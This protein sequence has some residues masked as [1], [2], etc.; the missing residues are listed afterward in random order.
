VVA[1]LREDHLQRLPSPPVLENPPPYNPPCPNTPLIVPSKV[2]SVALLC[3]EWHFSSL[4]LPK[5]RVCVTSMAEDLSKMERVED[6]GNSQSLHF[7]LHQPIQYTPCG[8]N[9]THHPSIWPKTGTI[10]IGKCERTCRFCKA[11]CQT[12]AALRKVSY[13]L[14][15]QQVIL[16]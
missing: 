9:H 13:Y 16:S 2:V 11:W 1:S 3:K 6:P 5:S 4:P 10:S 12:A 15:T 14:S 8:K 7:T